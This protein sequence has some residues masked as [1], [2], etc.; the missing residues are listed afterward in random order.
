[1]EKVA[2]MKNINFTTDHTDH[3]KSKEDSVQK[4]ATGLK[5]KKQPKLFNC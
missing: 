2:D 4:E 5:K 3:M 1:M